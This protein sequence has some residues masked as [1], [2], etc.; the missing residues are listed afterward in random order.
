[1]YVRPHLESFLD[2]VFIHFRVM[3]WSSAQPSSVK[4]M[5]QCFGQ[6]QKSKLALAWNRSHFGLS[7]ADYNNKAAT[8]KDLNRVWEKKGF[9]HF[10][11]SNTV[12]LDDSP[13]KCAL[14]PY[15]SIHL[16]TFDHKDPGFLDQGDQVLLSVMD[17]LKRIQQQT[18]IPNFIRQVPFTP[19]VMDSSV[20]DKSCVYYSFT[21]P[22]D[23][24]TCDFSVEQPT[25]RT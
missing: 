22:G 3:V 5:M 4:Q 20:L 2:Y 16:P 12:I 15:N 1:M 14:Q 6:T 13:S 8:L 24:L 17:Y 21:H 19:T 7:P 25:S 11:A 10:D 18:N 23:P 9:G